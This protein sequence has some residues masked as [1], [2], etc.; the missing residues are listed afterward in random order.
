MTLPTAQQLYPVVDATW[1][2]ARHEVVGPWCIRHGAGGGKRASAATALAR[3][4]DTDIPLAEAAMQALS[5]DRLFMIREG[6][7][8]LD[9]MLAARGYAIIDPVTLF[10]CPVD[11]LARGEVPPVSGFAIWPPLAIM[12]DIWM[13]AGIGPARQAL[14]RRCSSPKTGILGR[15][16]DRAAGVGFVALHNE[17]AMIHA[18][19]VVPELRRLGT[20]NNIMRLAARW[21]QRN[22]AHSLALAVTHTND[23]AN[24]LYRRLGMSEIGQY[25]YRIAP[26]AQAQGSR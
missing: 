21:A 24:A 25:H 2:A 18:L 13:D 20:A 1:P 14:M 12:D 7:S 8:A 3:V 22:G 4:T 16:Q 6:D 15:S 5:Q 11:V 17:I 9:G 10:A 23:A 26:A 19:E